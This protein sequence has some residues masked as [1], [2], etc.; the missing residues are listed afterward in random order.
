MRSILLLA[1][2]CSVL[3]VRPAAATTCSAQGAPV[4][5]RSEGITERVG[6]ILIQC[7]GATPGRPVTTNLTIFLSALLSNRLSP[8]GTIDASLTA[9]TGSGPVL[10]SSSAFLNSSYILSFN[11][12][13]VTPST[14]GDFS[15][16]VAGIRVNASRVPVNAPITAYLAVSG[17]GEF[18]LSSNMVTLGIPQTSLFTS[19]SASLVNCYGSPVPEVLNLT[20]LFAGTVHSTVRVTEALP[21]AFEKRDATTMDTGVRLILRFSGFPKTARIFLPNIIAGSSATQPTQGFGLGNTP[22]VGQYTPS[23]VGSLLLTRGERYGFER[24]RRSGRLRT[25]P[26][27][28]GHRDAR[29]RGRSPAHRRRRLCRPRSGRRQSVSR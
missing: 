4:Q 24:R 12:L 16:R 29:R 3:C 6:D 20:N 7:S 14:G 21:G 10:L 27:R 17:G 2:V 26:A 19:Q 5:L 22:T 23:T 8:A 18:V 9:D 28:F 11:G 25:G 1:L 15:L 13:T